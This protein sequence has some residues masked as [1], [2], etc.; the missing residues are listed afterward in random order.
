[1]QYEPDRVYYGDSA[2]PSQLQN[3]ELYQGGLFTNR[4]GAPVF[5]V[6]SSG[7]YVDRTNNVT[8]TLIDR[9][10]TSQPLYYLC[11][12]WFQ[13]EYYVEGDEDNPYWQ[14]IIFEDFLDDRSKEWQQRYRTYR[15][16]K[17]EA[18]QEMSLREIP[19]E[20]AY[21]TL[22]PGLEYS[23]D[24]ESMIVRQTDYIQYRRGRIATVM[25]SNPEYSL[26]KNPNVDRD[27]AQ[28]GLNYES[29][30]HEAVN[31][32]GEPIDMFNMDEVVQTT[33]KGHW[34]LNYSLNTTKNF[35]N[36]QDARS[37]I[38]AVTELGLF[39]EAHDMIA[40]ATFPPVIYD[41][42]K[43]HMSVNLLIKQGEFAPIDD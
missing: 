40:Y 39:N 24:G 13:R 6:N 42:A 31:R 4:N 41:S 36:P 15:R 34:N 30:F 5:R 18:G 27:N 23:R 25:V 20:E 7:E 9:T 10:R 38:V 26:E 3:P 14:Y 1:A 12:D 22:F 28:Y 21:V 32:E 11:Q 16:V 19:D 8:L 43:H 33:L 35:A 37:S 17:G 2:Y 29:V